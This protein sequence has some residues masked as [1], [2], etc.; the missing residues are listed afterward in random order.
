MFV[1]N[2]AGLTAARADLVAILQTGIPSG[3]IL[4]IQNFTGS[5][6]GGDMMRLNMAIAPASNP[7]VLGILGGDLAGFPN[8]RRV[9]DDV[10][11]IE[12]RAIAGATHPL[13]DQRYTLD[14]AATKVTQGLSPSGTGVTLTLTYHPANSA[15]GHGVALEVFQNGKQIGNATDSTGSGTAQLK[16]T[17]G[18]GSTLLIKVFNYIKG[19]AISFSLTQS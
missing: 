2:L 6:P 14:A 16:L 7:N 1:P 9:M 18:S 10:V 13:V 3:I 5:N 12:L 19:Q 4:G 11:T 15:I 17:P 8:G